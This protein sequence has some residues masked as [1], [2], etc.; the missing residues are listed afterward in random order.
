MNATYLYSCD[1]YEIHQVL[2]IQRHLGDHVDQNQ[3]K[4][5]SSVSRALCTN[6]I[7]LLDAPGPT[8][9]AY[10]PD[11]KKLVTVGSDAVI[12]VFTTGSDGEPVNIDVT[13]DVHTCLTVAND[14]FIVGC[15]DGSV[16]KFS[17]RTNA[18]D[19]ILLRC[20]LPV[21]DVALSPDGLWVAVASEYVHRVT[22]SVFG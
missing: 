5:R 10:T 9:T 2:L 8:Y 13:T 11:G 6:T 18:F 12:R 22:S 17:L 1:R 20:T 3:A 19:E 7:D 16:S 15:E 4:A 14:F 21:R